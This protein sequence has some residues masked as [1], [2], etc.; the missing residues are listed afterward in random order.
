MN[1]TIIWFNKFTDWMYDP[2]VILNIMYDCNGKEINLQH[3]CCFW[4]ILIW[5][6]VNSRQQIDRIHS[7]GVFNGF[8]QID[9]LVFFS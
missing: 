7:F 5:K 2:K 3:C 6:E 8:K 1:V 4:M 9:P